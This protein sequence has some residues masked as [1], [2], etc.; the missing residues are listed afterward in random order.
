MGLGLKVVLRT[1]TAARRQQ[2]CV[3]PPNT[4]E[5]VPEHLGV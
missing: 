2:P 5:K 1:E 3:V 4:A